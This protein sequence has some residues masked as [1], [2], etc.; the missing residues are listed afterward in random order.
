MFAI[1]S[2]R[3]ACTNLGILPPDQPAPNLPAGSLIAW[4]TGL[5]SAAIDTLAACGARLLELRRWP[6]SA[7][8]G[9]GRSGCDLIL[10]RQS[11][12]DGFAA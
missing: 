9:T 1:E 12:Q 7:R 2:L 6:W 8:I 3:A 11:A 10:V 5:I 4:Y